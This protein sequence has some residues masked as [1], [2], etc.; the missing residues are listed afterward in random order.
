M[1]SGVL[2]SSNNSSGVF[3]RVWLDFY[4]NELVCG[5][6]WMSPGKRSASQSLHKLHKEKRTSWPRFFFWKACGYCRGLWQVLSW[7]QL[8]NSWDPPAPRATGSSAEV[9][10]AH[11]R[12]LDSSREGNLKTVFGESSA[13]Q[14][15]TVQGLRTGSYILQITTKK[16]IFFMNS[17]FLKQH[18]V[19][20][21]SLFCWSICHLNYFNHTPL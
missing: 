9:S 15:N 13:T 2:E 8:S 16:G 6:C 20:C 18:T 12:A 4:W 3:D 7:Q 21:V 1:V 10:T 5:C 17:Y 19:F 14:W 11:V